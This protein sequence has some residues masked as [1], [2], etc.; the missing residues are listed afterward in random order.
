MAAEFP[1]W[2][3]LVLCV[4]RST[5]AIRPELIRHLRALGFVANTYDNV[6]YPAD[7]A[8]DT[9]AA[10]IEAI[11]QHDIV[12]AVLDEQEGSEVQQENIEAGVRDYLQQEGLLPTSGSSVPAP[13]VVQLEVLTAIARG[14]PTL[15]LID[16]RARD[17]VQEILNL[18]RTGALQVT[19]KASGVPSAEDLIAAEDWRGLAQA[20]EVPA[21]TL[22]SF[23][24]LLFLHGLQDTRWAHYYTPGNLEDLREKATAALANVPLALVH[25]AF[26]DASSQLDRARPPVGTLSLG[27]LLRRQLILP[28]P[29]KLM[30]GDTTTE[31]LYS[32]VDA[33]GALRR[34]LLERRSVLVLGD[35][36]LGKST[37]TMLVHASLKDASSVPQLGVLWGRWRDLK[38]TA[39][40]WE[41]IVR[42]LLGRAHGRAPWPATLALPNLPWVLVL[43]GL[44]ESP[45]PAP[46][47][48]RSLADLSDHTT[49]LVSCRANDI[50]RYQLGGANDFD[51][52]V[53]LTPWEDEQLARYAGALTDAGY[54]LGAAAVRH[55]I[56]AQRRPTV[57]GYPLW[58]AMLVYL[59][60][61]GE[62]PELKQLNDYELVRRTMRA[63]GVQ[64]LKRHGGDTA[65]EHALFAALGS[66]AWLLQTRRHEGALALT[67]L[68]RHLHLRDEP[69]MRAVQSFLD[70]A[71]EAVRGFRHEVIHDYW[72]G[73]HIASALPGADGLRLLALLGSQRRALANDAIR[74]TLAL[75]DT[76][77]QAVDTLRTRFDEIPNDPRTAFVKNQ[78]L[79]FLGRLDDG[80]ATQEFLARLSRSQETDFVRYSAAFTGAMIGA[81]GVEQDYY[82]RLREDPAS[83]QLNRGYHLFYH[84]DID[85]AEQDMP[86]YDDAT[87]RPDR[88]TI[89]LIE[90]LKLTEPKHRRLRRIE[91]LT[92]RRFIETRPP[93][94]LEPAEVEPALAAVEAETNGGSQREADIRAEIAAIRIALSI[95]T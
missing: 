76:T 62:E 56:A 80:S 42:T 48:A 34:W 39:G 64:E 95:K 23:R 82:T 70:V 40:D 47:T 32:P 53:R 68:E 38:P 71:D 18:L 84:G 46:D 86:S 10:C 24:H 92:L 49:L 13:T 36:G 6:G 12:L 35:P 73:Q 3:V 61:E 1:A 83:D 19:P 25:S 79:Y 90:R 22:S 89:V 69:M 21:G 26:A 54:I 33:T 15:P 81:D 50:A 31:D 66:T 29:Y 60:E 63:V 44:D 67:E 27:D 55:V 77:T 75:Q 28:P 78:M 94:L 17:A 72:L 91:L 7:P 85:V 88:A 37:L 43:D 8:R 51:R 11:D 9:V 5:E 14:K 59:A 74:A 58:L 52:Q 65:D 4:G 87:V 20:Y 93:G 57:I 2:R 41:N 45:L 16:A 30:S